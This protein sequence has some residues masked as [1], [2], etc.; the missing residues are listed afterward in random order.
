MDS[1]ASRAQRRILLILALLSAVVLVAPWPGGLSVVVTRALASGPAASGGELL[2]EVPLLLLAAVTAAAALAAWF[3][4]PER[5][6]AV[7]GGVVGVPLAYL[8]GESVKRVLAQP[9][10][11][12]AWNLPGEC[13]PP[14]DWSLPSSHATLAFAAVV[15]ISVAAR[16]VWATGMATL[17]ALLVA[18]GR[19]L[20]GMHY[21]HDVALGALVGGGVTL[22][23]V[24]VGV[25]LSRR[26]TGSTDLAVTVRRTLR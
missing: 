15:V 3:R 20:E 13:P 5:R 12:S 17:A 25:A 1:L 16:S 23:V 19:M 7:L 8:I 22:A 14:D 18:T 2:S 6:P 10:P 11:C 24:L 9:R 21:L 4:H 26:S